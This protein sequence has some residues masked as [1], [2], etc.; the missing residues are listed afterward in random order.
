MNNLLAEIRVNKKYFVLFLAIL[1]VGIFLRTYHFHDWLRF[2]EDE[3]RDAMIISDAA[4]GRQPLPLLGPLAGTSEFRLGPGYYYLQYASAL[5]FG[6]LPEK[7]AY[8]DLFFSI[9]AI[10][11]LYLLLK[12][13]FSRNVSLAATAIFS[14]SFFIIK[15]SRFAW[16]PNSAP[17]FS[18]L[19]LYAFLQLADSKTNRK[20]LWAVLAGTALGIGVQ[21]HTVFLLVFPL[22]FLIAST[23]GII[24]KIFSWRLIGVVI[25]AALVFNIPQIVSEAQNRGAN[26]K[27]FFGEVLKRDEKGGSVFEKII[28]AASCEMQANVM[29][30]ANLASDNRCNYFLQESEKIREN[31]VEMTALEKNYFYFELVIGLIFTLGGYCLIIFYL[32]REIDPQKKNFLALM[33]LLGLVSVAVLTPMI[34]GVYT[35]FLLSLVAFSFFVL[36]L[37]AKYLSEKFK[38]HPAVFLLFLAIFFAVVNFVQI[39]KAYTALSA[40]GTAEENRMESITLGEEKFLS[41]FILRNSDRSRVAYIQGDYADIFKFIEPARFFFS[42][43]RPELAVKVQGDQTEAEPGASYFFVKMI[44]R[45]ERRVQM[46]RQTIDDRGVIDKAMFARFVIFKLDGPLAGSDNKQLQKQ[47]GD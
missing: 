3:A 17:F 20:Y 2:S 18:M 23:F 45:D 22:I 16:N 15:Y 41:D 31:P 46:F 27:A 14:F 30:T 26:T 7:L 28:P 39:K 40:D 33:L 43:R 8:P 9:L 21:L 25:L 32:R 1:A 37:W 10:L 12:K 19:F 42:S 13:Y 29:I 47:I 24:K 38:K 4:A 44:D 5:I 36:A 6:N 34:E 11:L 35:R